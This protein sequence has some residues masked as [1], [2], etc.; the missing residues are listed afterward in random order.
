MN[1]IP[2]HDWRDGMNGLFDLSEQTYRRATGLNQSVLKLGI[3]SPQHIR[4]AIRLPMEQTKA[5]D[6]GQLVHLL[7]LTP[8]EFKDAYAVKPR[9]YNAGKD[10]QKPWNANANECK[11]WL[12]AHEGKMIVS[13]RELQDVEN[14]AGAFLYDPWGA[15]FIQHG[16]KEVSMF[17]VEPSTGLKVKGK[18]DILCDLQDA[19]YI[20]DLKK[21]ADGE[22]WEFGK[23]CAELNYHV[24][25]GVLMWLARE[26]VPGAADKTIRLLHGAI[27]AKRPHLVHWNELGFAERHLGQLE[28]MKALRGYAT[29]LKSNE[30]SKVQTIEYPQWRLERA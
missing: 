22:P 11:A 13:E 24:Q 26:L 14:M 10:G 28:F 1:I 6:I 3:N 7:L 20:V 23:K 19:L 5:M 2:E 18:A 29:A 25:V 9:T 12:A 30:W 17:A 4:E 21:V 27:D 15:A 16:H 8:H